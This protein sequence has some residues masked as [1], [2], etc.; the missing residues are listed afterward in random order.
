MYNIFYILAPKLIFYWKTTESGDAHG[1]YDLPLYQFEDTA[2][3]K[4]RNWTI[5]FGLMHMNTFKKTEILLANQINMRKK[6]TKMEC[7]PKLN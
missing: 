5:G 1:F 4:W 3:W 7:L 2:T 6:Y